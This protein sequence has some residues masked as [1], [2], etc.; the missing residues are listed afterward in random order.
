MYKKEPKKILEKI[1]YEYETI[2]MNCNGTAS[3]R[4]AHSANTQNTPQSI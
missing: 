1:S 2:V 3:C 4:L